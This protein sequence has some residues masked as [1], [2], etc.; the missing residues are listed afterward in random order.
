MKSDDFKLEF[1]KLIRDMY[2]STTSEDWKPWEELDD[3]K[4]FYEKFKSE[5]TVEF[6]VFFEDIIHNFRFYYYLNFSPTHCTK[7]IVE[8]YLFFK[9][10]PDDHVWN[11]GGECIKCGAQRGLQP[12]TVKPEEL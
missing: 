4:N 12:A 11:M 9:C 8:K 1:K 7:E 10:K 2:E 6:D 5:I 3:I